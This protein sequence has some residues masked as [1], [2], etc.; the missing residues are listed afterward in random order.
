[1]QYKDYASWI[2]QQLQQDALHMSR[3]YWMDRLGDYQPVQTFEWEGDAQSYKGE[4]LRFGLDGNN[5]EALRQLANHL[6]LTFN[7]LILASVQALIF[8]LTEHRDFCIGMPVGGRTHPDLHQLLGMFAN[9]VVLRGQYEAAASFE[10]FCLKA[11][12]QVLHS[13][14]YQDYPLSEL[15]KALH[16]QKMPFDMMVAFQDPGIDVGNISAFEG[17]SL[18]QRPVS[19]TL[20]RLPLTLNFFD[21][22]D[23]LC[24]ETTYDTGVYERET[25][26]LLIE[27]Y[28][29][30]LQGLLNAPDKPVMELDIT[31]DIETAMKS[32]N[33]NIEFH[34]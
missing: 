21:M 12:E 10:D 14:Q 17:F 4:L 6:G 28:Q 25:I 19:H 18:E 22:G 32:D 3:E 1:V 34:F 7:Q 9:T 2:S 33:L 20:S 26:Q 16:L 31:L 11:R 15:L 27:R 5:T 13:L 29:K 30:L 8:R 24:C 23:I